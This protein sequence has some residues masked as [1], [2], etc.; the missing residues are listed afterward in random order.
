MSSSKKNSEL[1]DIVKGFKMF[2]SD[3]NGLI[4]PNELKEIMETMNMDEKNPFIYNIIVDL[5]SD[6]EIRQKGGI[7]AGD[8]IS[9][10]DQELNDT[11]STDGLQNIFSI[12]SN[13]STNTIPLQVFNQID[14]EDNSISGELNKIKNLISKPE[15]NGKELN[16]QEFN[17]IME[18]MNMD[19]KNPFIYICC[20][21]SFGV[22]SSIISLNS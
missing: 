2:S 4:N 3:N 9:S 10:L 1:N 18:T 19:E 6:P 16:F 15:I 20:S 17:E 13:S 21:F 12:F 11:S 14:E 5:C 7:D 8:F 22:S